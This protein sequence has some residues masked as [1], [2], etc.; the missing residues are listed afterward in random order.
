MGFSDLPWPEDAQ[1]FPKHA[2]V[3]RYI[4]EYSQD[5]RHLI[6][7]ETQVL[8]LRQDASEKWTIKT[9]LVSRNGKSE[10]STHHFDAVIIA[11]GHFNIP[12]VPTVPGIEAWSAAHPG[13]IT[14][15]KFYRLPESYTNRKVIIVG[16]SASGIDIAAQITPFAQ[17]PLILSSKSESYLQ[18]STP[19]GQLD[20]P[21]ISAFVPST[22]TVEFEDGSQESDVDAILYCTG[23]FYSFPFISQEPSALGP[24]IPPLTT[25]GERVENTYQHLFYRP[26]PT[27]AFPV[28]NQKVIPFPFAEAQSAVIARVFSGR[29]A[30]P[31]EPE[32]KAWEKEVI[33]KQGDGR[34]FHVLKFPND[35][36][37][38]NMMHDWALQADDASG[39]N[40]WGTESKTKPQPVVGKPPPYW[41]EKEY[42]TRERF[43]AIKKAFQGLGE[44]RHEVRTLPEVGFDFE[45]WKAERERE[46]EGE[47]L[48]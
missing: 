6:S 28:L 22:R 26:N 19:S 13:T 39:A 1:L 32:M 46:G 41:G 18:T 4:E 31:S 14:H 21:P 38:I 9:Q 27:L 10:V 12:Y 33:E 17:S 11:N 45:G 24:D 2:E 47:K 36:D 35:A 8:D 44:K 48:I 43:P 3:Q 37:Y 30:L 34:N 25:T 16:N 15:S 7:F 5:V 42:W 40:H 29:L 20:K 23:Y